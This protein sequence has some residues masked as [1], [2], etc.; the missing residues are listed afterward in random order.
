MTLTSNIMQ[1]VMD[2]LGRRDVLR[3]EIYAPYYVCSFAIHCFNLMNQRRQIYWEGGEVPNLRLH[4]IF[5]A[6]AGYMK[7]YFLKQMGGGSYALLRTYVEEENESG[8]QMI[9]AQNLNEAGLVGTWLKEGERMTRKHGLAE[10]HAESFILVDEFKGITDA[11]KSNGQMDTQLLAGL[12][13]GHIAKDMAGGTIKFD[14]NFT[15]WGGVQPGR[16]DLEGGMGRRMLFLVNNPD[17]TIKQELRR[18]QF[19]AKNVRTNESDIQTIHQQ[20]DLW[21]S[22]LDTIDSIEFDESI[23]DLYDK[24]DVESYDTSYF[25]RMILGYHLATKGPSQHILLT[26]KNPDLRELIDREI[27]WR[28]QVQ[29]GPDL[30]QIQNIITTFGSEINGMYVI[31][32]QVFLERCASVSITAMK[33]MKKLEEL[34]HYGLINKGGS[35]ITMAYE[36]TQIVDA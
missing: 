28:K 4:I 1:L 29:M 34:E 26:A 3:R 11:L 22:S 19:K 18:A 25:D 2:E 7:S 8:V 24:Y 30:I 27:E 10:R 20:I 33:A 6:P 32:R 35:N 16:Y 12:D 17:K 36:P 21:R 13:H 15:M 5:V 31:K 23:L 14:T 9:Y